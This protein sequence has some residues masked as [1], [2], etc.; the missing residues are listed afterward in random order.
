MLFLIRIYIISSLVIEQEGKTNVNG[1]AFKILLS[2]MYNIYITRNT[3]YGK[4]DH[5]RGA[6]K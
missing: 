2:Y 1:T 4:Q 3:L 5:E 6:T